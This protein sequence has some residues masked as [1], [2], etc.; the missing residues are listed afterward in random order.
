MPQTRVERQDALEA[1]MAFIPGAVI[2]LVEKIV[3]LSLMIVLFK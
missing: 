1:L 3:M 2:A